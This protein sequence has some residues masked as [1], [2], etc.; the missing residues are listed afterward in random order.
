MQLQAVSSIDTGLLLQLPKPN[1]LLPRKSI[2][3]SHFTE[4][5]L[6]FKFKM[7][8]QLL[9]YSPWPCLAEHK[10]LFH[11]CQGILCK[12]LSKIVGIA[13]PFRQIKD[14]LLGRFF[15]KSSVKCVACLTNLKELSRRLCK[16]SNLKLSLMHTNVFLLNR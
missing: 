16:N 11:F 3:V 14:F 13:L 15:K 5:G 9:Y 4:V 8:C 1:F 10:C 2:A 12:C 7:Y 6:N